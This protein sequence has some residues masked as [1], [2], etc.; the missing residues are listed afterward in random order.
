MPVIAQLDKPYGVKVYQGALTPDLCKR[1][2]A[3][4]EAQPKTSS[5]ALINGKPRTFEEL[6]TTEQ[7]LSEDRVMGI[8]MR[9][10]R[11][12]LDTYL[13]EHIG[14]DD[15][16]E[17][18]KQG[19]YDLQPRMKRYDAGDEFP[20]HS[21]DSSVSA[22]A[23]RFAYIVYLNDDFEGGDT[24]F[25]SGTREVARIHPEEGAMLVFPIHPVFMHQGD[26]IGH[27]SKYIFNGFASVIT[28]QARAVQ[29]YP[30]PKPSKLALV[31]YEIEMLHLE[32]LEGAQ[33]V[34]SNTPQ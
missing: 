20:L 28:S 34:F 25:R 8:V 11:D 3:Y 33:K 7:L 24:F 18:I 14:C 22:L 5:I 27:G 4:F 31:T 29:T 16:R 13:D 30:S 12:T 10:V 9:K 32:L 23:R 17:K 15:L 6:L 26:K 2:I 1:A 19:C 21:D